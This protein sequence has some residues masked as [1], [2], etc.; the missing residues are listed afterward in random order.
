M[1]RFV[2]TFAL[3]VRERRFVDQDLR[4]SRRIEHGPGPPRVTGQDDFSSWSRRAEHLL[5]VDCPSVGERNRLATLEHS[6]QRS[7]RD[8]ERRRSLDVELAGPRVFNQRVA[9]RGLTVVN[10]EDADPV[11]VAVE[12]VTGPQLDQRVRI[13]ELPEDALQ[14][15]KEVDEPRRPVDCEGNLAT[16]K[17][18]RL[19]H[20]W[21]AEV[22]IGV[23]VRQEHLGQLDEADRRPKQLPLRALTAVE[24]EA[25]A[26]APEEQA[27]GSAP[28]RR[29]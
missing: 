28:C 23:I 9:D 13:R 15:T 12:D 6:E 17:G 3:F 5:R 19:H 10:L 2:R 18:E 24:E 27:G 21:Q 20:P 16:A 4:T 7:R 14:R 1:S 26:P 25:L 29:H 11:P 22:M 8:P